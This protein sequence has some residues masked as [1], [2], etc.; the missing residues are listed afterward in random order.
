M[1]TDLSGKKWPEE[2]TKSEAI[3]FLHIP[4]KHF[5]NY[6]RFSKEIPSFK[7]LGRWYFKKID[8]EKWRTLKERRTVVLNLQQYEECFEFAIRMVYSSTGHHGTGIR[9][10]RSEM[11]AADDWILGILA[12]FALKKFLKERFDTE[13]KLDTEVH[14]GFITPQDVDKVVEKGVERKPHICVAVKASKIKSCYLVV[15]EI[16][17]EKEDRKS[18]VYVFARVGLPS[19]HLFRFLRDHSFIKRA[20]EFLEKDDRLR[21]IGT[22]E[23]V[24]VW[25]CGFVEHKDLDKVTEIPGQVF[26]KGYR[27]V[28]SVAEMRN[29]DEDWKAF[30]QM[31]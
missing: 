1:Q 12:E 21:K 6:F 29:S 30:V 19:D 24:K 2:L 23:D 31:L 22:L 8:L 9:G 18:D 20:R 5:E 16:E 27:Y 10:E 13:I 26:S 11:Q 3:S 17:Y 28:K 7:Q 25:L 4:P 15:P 14:P